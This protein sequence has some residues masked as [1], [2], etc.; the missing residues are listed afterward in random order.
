MKTYTFV[1][2]THKLKGMYDRNRL[3]HYAE[4]IDA[5]IQHSPLPFQFTLQPR[6]G[7]QSLYDLNRKA[8]TIEIDD[9][10]KLWIIKKLNVKF[11]ISD[12]Q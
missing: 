10:D 9:I 5:Q 8:F 3:L 12:T 7:A 4:R 1:E 2:A 11:Y 6:P